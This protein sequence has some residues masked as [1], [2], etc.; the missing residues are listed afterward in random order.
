MTETNHITPKRIHVIRGDARA[1]QIFHPQM[2]GYP[3]QNCKSDDLPK[4]L[5][6]TN[7]FIDLLLSPLILNY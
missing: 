2:W 6:H 1:T 4:Q 7:H 5:L 3:L